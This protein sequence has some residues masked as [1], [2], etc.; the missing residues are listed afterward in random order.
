M[1]G[2]QKHFALS[3]FWVPFLELH[4]FSGSV[5]VSLQAFVPVSQTIN[6]KNCPAHL[7]SSPATSTSRCKTWFPGTAHCSLEEDGW[8]LK[9]YFTAHHCN[10]NR[11]LGENL[12]DSFGENKRFNTVNIIIGH[13][14]KIYNCLLHDE[15]TYMNLNIFKTLTN[16]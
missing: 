6:G 14:L 15:S 8:T 1:S 9:T 13:F 12:N 7:Q 11:I 2:G 10:T 16:G 4:D 3:R 5:W